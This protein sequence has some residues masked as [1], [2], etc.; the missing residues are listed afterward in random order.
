MRVVDGA[1]HDFLGKRRGFEVRLELKV[2]DGLLQMRSSRQWLHLGSARLP[3]PRFATVTIFESWSEGR[4]H[5]DVRLRS[6]ALGEWFRYAG[7]FSYRYEE[8]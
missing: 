1:L 2:V 4:Q 3:L 5:V 8:Q 7:S 6:A